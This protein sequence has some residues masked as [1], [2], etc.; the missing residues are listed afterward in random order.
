MISDRVLHKLGTLL[1]IQYFHDPVL[2]ESNRVRTYI[3]RISHFLH[4]LAF[5]LATARLR[6]AVR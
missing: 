6:A 1:G 2:M 5:Q 3:Q 4:R